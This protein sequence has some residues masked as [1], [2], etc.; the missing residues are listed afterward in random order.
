MVRNDHHRE[1]RL[2]Q[3]KAWIV[4][5]RDLFFLIQMNNHKAGIVSIV[6]VMLILTLP[7]LAFPLSQS[8]AATTLQPVN[9]GTAGNF[10][11]LAESG[12][13]I[14]G[15]TGV[16]I[17]GS[18]AVSP[19]A[20]T[21][22]TGFGLVLDSSGTFA[23][24]SLV[25]G[26]VYAANYAP[27]TP[28]ML[29]TAVNNMYTAYT[30][31]NGLTT[32]APVVNFEAGNLGGQTLNALTT[33]NIYKWSTGVDIPIG[34]TLTL[35]CS[36]LPSA[37]FV[38]Q[39]AQGLTVEGNLQL[40]GGCQPQNIF[41]VD[42]SAGP[43]GVTLGTTLGSLTSFAGVI[44]SATTIALNPGA[45]L[46]GQAL[47]QT[48]VTMAGGNTITYAAPT[49]TTTSSS[50]ST[51]SSSTSTSIS[52]TTS[53]STTRTS[54]TSSSTTAST[55][56]TATSTSPPASECAFVTGQYTNATTHQIVYFYSIPWAVAY[57]L[58]ND[59][60]PSGIYGT[61]ASPPTTT[62]TTLTS[63]S[64]SCV[65]LTVNSVTSSGAALT[66]EYSDIWNASQSIE[67]GLTP[68]TF[69]VT[70]NTVLTVGVFDSGNYAF[71]HWLDTGSALR[72]RTFSISS[73]TVFT[74]V[75]TNTGTP[76]PPTDSVISVGT[77]NVSNN[78]I[79]GY[80]TTLWQGATLVQSCFSPSRSP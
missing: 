1:R 24:S 46:T 19:I 38:F 2:L 51:T 63:I 9:L 40:T 60:G 42:A 79:A 16:P 68:V 47:S 75:Y 65:Y 45:S 41:W 54:T 25:S 27:P 31:A 78:P 14:T 52:S 67:N 49:T 59:F 6:V 74:A 56:V 17:T 8:F 11:I 32:P 69:C 50:T 10:A 30:T 70:P 22:I 64:A 20:S 80:Y 21:A 73:N 71:A 53:S 29:T 43:I 23:R 33:G 3:G 15:A 77:V 36:A 26:D 62:T 4:T 48:A 58:V 18:I 13:S 44:L 5:L 76:T 12:I 55:T 34:T 57:Q 61:C 28:T 35:D 37:V 72:F 66:G 7:F 39:I